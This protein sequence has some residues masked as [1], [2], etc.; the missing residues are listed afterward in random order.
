MYK[1]PAIIQ[2]RFSSKRLAGKV[3]HNLCGKPILKYLVESLGQCTSINQVFVITSTDLSDDSV[4][5]FCEKNGA[6]YY[7]GPLENVAKRMLDAANY[8]NLESFVRINGDSPLLNSKILD[9]GISIFLKDEYDLVTNT[10]PR[11]FPV[12]QSVE[13]I[14]TRSF[15]KA[16]EKMSSPD[17][18]EHV[19]K[20]Y[21]DHPNEFKIKNFSND[22]NLS[23]Y[24]LVVDTAEDLH[25]ME[26]II[27]SM[28]KDHTDYGLYELIELYHYNEKS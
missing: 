20:Y 15:E 7:R 17:H 22:D 3:L 26:K 14:K 25:R 16:Y 9:Q 18:F 28:T 10:F 8:F 23:S 13:V 19:T 4:V 21:Y 1:L 27:G 2:A 11:T 12:G 24:R 6:D 5:S